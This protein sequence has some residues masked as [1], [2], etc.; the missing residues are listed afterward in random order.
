MAGC[1]NF[2]KFIR[3]QFPLLEQADVPHKEEASIKFMPLPQ[4][5][6]YPQVQARH[7]HSQ[8]YSIT[9]IKTSS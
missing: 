8:H 1:Q 7:E 5:Y 3:V 4:T 2:L 6:G 9:T